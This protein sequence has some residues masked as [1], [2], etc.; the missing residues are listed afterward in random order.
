M[1]TIKSILD[2]LCLFHSSMKNAFGFVGFD[3]RNNF[4]YFDENEKA[5]RN[6][7]GM[8]TIS[9]HDTVCDLNNLASEIYE[10]FSNR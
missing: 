3:E 9:K 8:Y 6:M 2:H 5:S 1:Y 7:V 10:D 4:R